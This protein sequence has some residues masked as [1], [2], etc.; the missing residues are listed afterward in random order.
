MDDYS[1]ATFEAD[2][3]FRYDGLHRPGFPTV[4][5]D[6]LR[7]FSYTGFPHTMATRTVSSG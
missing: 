6:V 2:G 4:L 1:Y 7:R 3:W 5:R